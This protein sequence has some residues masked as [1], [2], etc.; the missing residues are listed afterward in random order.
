LTGSDKHA[1][2]TLPGGAAGFGGHGQD[3]RAPGAY[4]T[5]DGYGREQGTTHDAGLTGHHDK[6]SSSGGGLL[7]RKKD[8]L[9]DSLSREQKAKAELDAAMAR[10]NEARTHADR[11]LNEK[12]QA[13]QAE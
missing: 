3:T 13:A 11:Q 8:D 7:G 1:G 12:E 5:Q 9:E 2:N 10:H 4:N 6:H